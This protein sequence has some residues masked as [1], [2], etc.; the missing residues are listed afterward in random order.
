MKITV[1]KRNMLSY[2]IVGLFGQ[3]GESVDMSPALVQELLK[4]QEVVRD[5]Q[6]LLCAFYEGK[7][8]PEGQ[9]K[10]MVEKVNDTHNR[11]PN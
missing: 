8:T 4:F 11:R 6:K 7:F 5:V 3:T 2:Y 1:R 10:R 9:L